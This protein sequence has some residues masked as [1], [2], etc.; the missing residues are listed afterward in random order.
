MLSRPHG[1]TWGERRHRRI[2]ERLVDELR[3]A[4]QRVHV[5]PGIQIQARE[6]LGQRFSRNPVQR[7]GDGIESA[8]DQGGARACSFERRG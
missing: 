2:S 5:D 3:T 7:K 6:S 4:P 8:G 1:D